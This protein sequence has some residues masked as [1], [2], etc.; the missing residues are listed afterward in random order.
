MSKVIKR[1]WHSDI[2]GLGL[3]RKDT[4]S[5]AYEAYVPDHLIGRSF[6]FEGD[7]AADIAD[8][9]AAMSRMN[10]GATALVDTE[11]LARILLRAEAVASSRIEGLEVGARR[12]LRAEAERSLRKSSSD[13]TATEVLGNIDAM[14]YGVERVV[15]GREITVDLLLEIHRRLLRGT[16]LD[17]YAGRVRETQNWIG[18]SDHNPCSAAYV[19][20]PPEHVS[21]LLDDLCAFCNTDELPAV[22]QAAIAHA[23]FE[24]IHPFVDGN[25]RAG[26][27]LIHLVLRRRGLAPR[28]LAPVSL[29]LATWART[30]VDGLTQYRYIGSP[31]SRKA[32]QGVNTW[33]ASF[34][35]ACTRCASDATAFQARAEQ[36][37]AQ[38]RARLGAIRANSA[39][40][41][42]LHSLPGAPILTVHSAEALIERTFKPT[43]AA[44]ERLVEAGILRPITITRRNRAYE[45]PEIIEAFTALER[46]LASPAGDTRASRPVR[47]VPY[48]PR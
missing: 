1:R 23:Q 16:H 35:G 32:V 10:A 45:A 19:P 31:T 5:C 20:P 11:A 8:A 40:D 17:A 30:Y 14:V 36:L 41:V 43:H 13:V 28:V 37:E 4:R 44:I 39:T 48:R 26:R 12:L 15:E 3:P 6:V 25:G 7:V 21:G 46:Q 24:T 42:L 47:P 27:A 34:S 2:G 38:W 29:V 33:V 9:E 18:G 22:A